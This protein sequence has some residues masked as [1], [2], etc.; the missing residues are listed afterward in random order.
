MPYYKVYLNFI[1]INLMLDVSSSLIMFP[2]YLETGKQYLYE[3]IKS[4]LL[5]SVPLAHLI[6][7]NTLDHC[8]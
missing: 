6:A 4:T 2:C 7:R 5:H 1:D 3:R 8:T